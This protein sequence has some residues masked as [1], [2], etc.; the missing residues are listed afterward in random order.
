[1]RILGVDCG[2]TRTGLGI[3]DSDGLR[4]SLVYTVAVQ[5]NVKDPMA[6]RLAMIYKE[7]LSV[8]EEYQPELAAVEEV[9]HHANVQSALKLAHVR[10]VALL[11]IAQAGIPCNEYSPNAIKLSV[12]GYGKAQKHQVQLMVK[13]LLRLDGA[14]PSEDA[15]DALAAAIC[16]ANHQGFQ[17]KL[18]SS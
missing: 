15:A 8:I 18:H 13:T 12:V 3:I 1:M 14:P 9:F 16:C 7:L 2:S 5:T 4:H 11:A 6:Q 10:G 17:R